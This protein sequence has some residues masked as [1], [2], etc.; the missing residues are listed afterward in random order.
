MLVD[1]FS[2]IYGHVLPAHN[3]NQILTFCASHDL[4]DWFQYSVTAISPKRGFSF[5]VKKNRKCRWD[6]N[7]SRRKILK[8]LEHVWSLISK[9]YFVLFSSRCCSFTN[10]LAGFGKTKKCSAPLKMSATGGL[11]LNSLVLT[12]LHGLQFQKVFLN[13]RAVMDRRHV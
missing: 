1:S 9:V 2:F 3:F 4:G 12:I 5:S 6:S 7:S 13:V 11:T 10:L 8:M